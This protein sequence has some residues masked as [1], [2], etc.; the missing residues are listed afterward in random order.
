MP[1]TFFHGQSPRR[2]Q[3][4]PTSIAETEISSTAG[5][6][7]AKNLLTTTLL[8]GFTCT[9]NPFYAYNEGVLPKKEYGLTAH[10]SSLLVVMI[11]RSPLLIEHLVRKIG[12]RVDCRKREQK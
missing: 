10:P 5:C 11:L 3:H 12:R 7:H 9:C 6:A 1:H 2:V 8:H 4:E